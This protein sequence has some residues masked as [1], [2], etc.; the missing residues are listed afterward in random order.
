M[1]A[2]NANACAEEMPS[3]GASKINN[4][5]RGP[6]PPGMTAIN[7]AMDDND[8]AATKG[9]GARKMP[10]ATATQNKRAYTTNVAS[11]LNANCTKTCFGVNVAGVYAAPGCFLRSRMN[12]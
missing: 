9:R 5:S 10:S 7:C 12:S 2:D 3:A 4:A 1:S 8:M 11:T 6:T